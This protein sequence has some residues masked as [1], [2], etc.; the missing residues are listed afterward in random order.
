MSKNLLHISLVRGFLLSQGM[1]LSLG[2]TLFLGSCERNEPENGDGVLLQLVSVKAGTITLIPGDTLKDIPVDESI[3]IRFNNILDTSTVS[4]NI[5]LMT[6][7]GGP[8]TINIS[9][10][11]DLMTIIITPAN[12]LE[13]LTD[14]TLGLLS[15]LKGINGESFPGVEYYFRTVQG[16]MQILNITINDRDFS[17]SEPL[18]DVDYQQLTVEVE[19][20][21]SLDP[22]NYKSFI[23]LSGNP[24]LDLKL[25]A[26]N[27]TLSVSTYDPLDDYRRYFFTISSS[28]KANNG[29]AFSGFSNHFYTRLDSTPKFLLITDDELLELIQEQTFKYFYDFAHPDCGLARERNT[30][31]D[32]VTSGGGGFG[33][34]A[35]IVGMERG[36]ISRDQGLGQMEKIVAFLE[37]S[38]RFY[39]AWPHWLYGSTGEVHPFS[40]KD[41]GGD[42]VE[43]AFMVQGLLTFRQYLDS[44]VAAE[45]DLRDRINL[46]WQGV[47]WDWYTRGEEVLYWHW[48]PNYNWDM[49]LRIQGINETLIVYILA[50][51][52]PTHAIDPELYYSG[53]MRNGSIVNGNDY[54]GINL[55]L[56]SPYGGPLFFTHYSYLGL[57]PRKLEDSYVTHWEQNVSHSLI[58]RAYCIDN[59]ADYI[60]YSADC[61]GLT[62]SDNHTGYSAHSPTNDLGVITPTA[63]ISSLPYT[64]EYSMD[65]I[66]HFYYILGD[67]L[68]GEYGFYDAFNVTEG[69]W[70]DSYLAIDQGPIVAMIENY[71]TGLLWD[72]FMSCPEIRSGL[73]QI[74]L[75]Y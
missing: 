12:P 1:I 22:D 48:S 70:A 69:W 18:R 25:S 59:P 21:D 37:T 39:G 5:V 64:P 20:S 24:V 6:E 11:A 26:D 54:Y 51:S 57:D 35:L 61:W 4:N 17:Q 62:A 8:G 19:F 49:N 73:D 27:R 9:Y 67:R 13:H 15:G 66:R 45:K 30:S 52:S 16:Y 42:L 58:N 72:L 40:L 23:V 28:L 32:I 34:M 63:A 2:F 75:R 65:A 50:A 55:P 41:D 71:R 14:Y 29:S 31:G 68:W 46:L 74:G 10:E 3:Y 44:T 47:E 43:T 38:D 36:F 53:Y 56:G 33:V 7:Q 60:G